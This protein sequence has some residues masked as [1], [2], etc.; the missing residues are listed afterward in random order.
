MDFKDFWKD[1][2]NGEDVIDADDINAIAN[3]VIEI[4]KSGIKGESDAVKYTEQSLNEK[5]QAQARE[6]IDAVNPSE[7]VELIKENVKTI[8]GEKG[9]DGI[10]PTVSVSKSGKVTTVTITDKDGAKIAT[11]NDGADGKDG[12]NGTNGI[13]PTATVSKSGK[14]TTLTITDVNG[15][16]TAVIKD[17]EDGAKGT[18]GKNGVDGTS[19]TITSVS[20]STESGGNNTVTFSD[21]KT[22][23]VKNGEKGAKGDTGATGAK[24]DTPIKGVDYFTESDKAEWIDDALSSTSTN[25]V[26]NKVIQKEFE[27]VDET[28]EEIGDFIEA[29]NEALEAMDGPL[30]DEQKSVINNYSLQN[31]EDAFVSFDNRREGIFALKQRFKSGNQDWTVVSGLVP[32]KNVSISI[33]S[34]KVDESTHTATG[35]AIIDCTV[36]DATLIIDITANNGYTSETTWQELLDAINADKYVVAR[37]SD[38][39]FPL[40]SVSPNDV[41]VIFKSI[42]DDKLVTFEAKEGTSGSIVFTL[43]QEKI[44]P[45]KGTDYW[46]E[47]DKQELIN[48]LA[49]LLGSATVTVDNNNAITI[50]GDLSDGTYTVSYRNTDGTTAYV[51]ALVVGEGSSIPTLTGLK[52]VYDDSTSVA[53]GTTLEELNEKVY[54]SYSDGSQTTMLVKNT[55][56]TLSG[57]LTAGQANTIKVTGKG[58]Y[59]AFATSFSVTVKEEQLTPTYTNLVP[60][61]YEPATVGSSGTFVV[62]DGV[63]YKNGAYASSAKPY[64]GTD[65]ACFCI[66]AIEVLNG[67]VL[68]VKGAVLEGTGHERMTML[69]HYV[70]S[71]YFGVPF[72]SLPT[73]CNV[74][75]LSDSY[76]KIDVNDYLTTNSIVFGCYLIISAKG[77]AN[78]VIVSKT[79]IE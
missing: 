37:F 62:W 39:L 46:T 6:N 74:T 13:S 60:T 42:S 65:S 41:N 68:Y 9:E 14:E 53:A 8:K 61:A 64:Y 79:P 33:D 72:A 52:V 32:G 35:D 20:E 18:D 78:E 59:S 69:N 44:I 34:A 43:T 3:A 49:I 66:G 58:I 19:V 17:G 21:G 67:E 45:Q 5:Q 57:N 38:M 23:T 56:Y 71:A 25:A 26:Q 16:K 22:L 47:E 36:E 29:T 54:G 73:G 55:D 28:F 24:G 40:A 70:G 2:V 27:Y 31:S 75:K 48:E 4:E 51:G 15:T 10:S 11:I 76:Y 77:T 50:V 30:T 12:A 1:K 63:G 7:V